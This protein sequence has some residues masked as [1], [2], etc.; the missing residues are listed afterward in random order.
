VLT[1]DMGLPSKT[2]SP[3][4]TIINSSGSAYNDVFV[5][6]A[7]EAQGDLVTDFYGAGRTVGDSLEFA[8]YGAGT[9]TQLGASDSYTITAD[10]AHGGITETFRLAGVFNLDTHV[11]S[12]DFLFV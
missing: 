2:L 1:G 11:G 8:G 3:N 5:F 6:R 12:N 4:G 7:G 10:A 9:I